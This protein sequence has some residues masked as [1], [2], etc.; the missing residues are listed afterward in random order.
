MKKLTLVICTLLLASLVA[1]QDVTLP[2]G[3]SLRVKLENTI[4]TSTNKAGDPFTGRVMQPVKFAD[5]TVIPV[6][7]EVQGRLTKVNDPRRIQGKPTI[8]IFPEALILPNGDRVTLNASL[9]DT[10]LHNGTSVNSEGQFKGKGHDMQD[11]TEIGVGTGVGMLAGGIF[12]G[13]KGL[14]VGG[15]IGATATVAHWLSKHNTTVLP[16]G[17]ELFMELSR[18]LVMTSAAAPAE[19]PAAPATTTEAP[20]GA[21][22]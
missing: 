4:T 22:Q 14:L 18:P 11:M 12:G 6:G 8:G 7:T 13:G 9:V 19:V 15:A 21:G 3:T 16:S 2:M 10:S 1:A 20:A 5:K 17:T